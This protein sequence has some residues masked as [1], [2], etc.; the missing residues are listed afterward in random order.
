MG[1]FLDPVGI[2]ICSCGIVRGESP[3]VVLITVIE[4]IGYFAKF[5]VLSIQLITCHLS[6]NKLISIRDQD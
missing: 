4:L 1:I 5:L 2:P 6:P 3:A